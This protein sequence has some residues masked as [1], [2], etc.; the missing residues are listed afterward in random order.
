[1]LT[2]SKKDIAK[3]VKTLLVLLQSMRGQDVVITLRNDNIV[4]GTI[5][6]VDANMN[7]ELKNATVEP[8]PFY[9]TS[10]QVTTIREED[11]E[12]KIEEQITL[13]R[14]HLPGGIESA[15][16]LTTLAAA[17]ATRQ[18]LSD[19]T[20]NDTPASVRDFID[21]SSV[22]TMT[23]N[24]ARQLDGG[25]L[26]GQFHAPAATVNRVEPLSC[27]LNDDEHRDIDDDQPRER[28]ILTSSRRKSDYLLVKG[29]RVRHVDVPADYDLVGG[30]KRELELVRNR[31][32]QWS[33]RDI[34]RL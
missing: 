22:Q 34:I 30:A 32:K 6:K 31:R 1:M 16:P 29:S 7:I 12:V 14:H 20:N 17:A 3:S 13:V 18:R 10:D 11:R 25:Q 9:N 28:G 4:K 23:S 21:R 8:D 33:K 15:D 2:T 24:G 19:T 27:E 5:L 26:Q